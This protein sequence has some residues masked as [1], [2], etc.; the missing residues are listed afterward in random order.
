[1]T[2]EEV[3][4]YG[5][6]A[7]T[8]FL[9][10]RFNHRTLNDAFSPL[11]LLLFFWVLPYLGSLLKL[12]G[13]QQGLTFEGHAL[14]LSATL[15]M[16]FPSLA[17]AYVLSR[18]RLTFSLDRFQVS[19]LQHSVGRRLAIVFLIATVL[20]ANSRIRSAHRWCDGSL[21]GTNQ[22]AQLDTIWVFR[23]RRGAADSRDPESA[24]GRCLH[25]PALLRGRGVL[26][27][28]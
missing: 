24:Q 18:S 7:A 9:W 2:L 27:P 6:I 22:Q 16:M 4:I 28:A 8:G 19:P 10:V 5:L 25:E 13:F 21:S 17:T 1:M 20:A 15:G 14:V 11:N 3:G 12:S 26:L 23:T